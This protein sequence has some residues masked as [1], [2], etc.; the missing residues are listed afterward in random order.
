MLNSKHQIV[1]HIMGALTP[2]EL[3]AWAASQSG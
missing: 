3:D 1:R 2:A